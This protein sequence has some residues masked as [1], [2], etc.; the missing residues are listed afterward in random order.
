[1]ANRD[2]IA[3]YIGASIR[4]TLEEENED[5]ELEV[6]PLAGADVRFTLI[7]EDGSRVTV[8][9][10]V[11][12]PSSDGVAEYVTVPVSEESTF[13]LIAGR[14]IVEP[15]YVFEEGVDEGA[16]KPVHFTVKERP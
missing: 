11:L 13:S 9:A 7:S 3:G 10:D 14:L 16:A 8:D 15:Y 2:L 4:I 6:V 5:G 1:M 12:S